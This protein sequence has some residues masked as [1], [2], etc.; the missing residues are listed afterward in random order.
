VP[1]TICGIALVVW[2]Q[3]RWVTQGLLHPTAAGAPADGRSYNGFLR[4]ADVEWRRLADRE[5]GLL[6]LGFGHAL[7]I[8][9]AQGI[10]SDEHINA[11]PR[12]TWPERTKRPSGAHKR[13]VQ[14]P[15][16][17]VLNENSELRPSGLRLNHVS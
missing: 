2:Q 5:T 9:A 14:R 4:F 12:G 17:R 6:M 13:E 15:V 16:T 11:L 3:K 1:S 7:T 10:T 8:D